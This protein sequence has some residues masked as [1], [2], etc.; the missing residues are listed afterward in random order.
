MTIT[1]MSQ[2]LVAILTGVLLS[3]RQALAQSLPQSPGNVQGT[4]GQGDFIGVFEN[5]A[6]QGISTLILVIGAAAFL[7]VGWAIVAKFNECRAGRAEWSEAGVTAGA[8]AAILIFSTF[9]LNQANTIFTT[10][11]P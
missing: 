10:T 8:G 4:A 9:L 6:G 2:R 3:S 11:P 5:L 1:S 7:L